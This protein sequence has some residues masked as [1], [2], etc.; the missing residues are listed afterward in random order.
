MVAQEGKA[1]DPFT[2]LKKT[3]IKKAKQMRNI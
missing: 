1:D 3:T 2:I